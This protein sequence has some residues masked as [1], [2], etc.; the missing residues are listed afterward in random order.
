MSFQPSISNGA[1]FWGCA[2]GSSSAHLGCYAANGLSTEYSNLASP[3]MKRRSFLTL[4]AMGCVSPGVIS[5][6]ESG[7]NKP[8]EASLFTPITEGVRRATTLTVYEGLP[9]QADIVQFR[10][11]LATKKT[12]RLQ[13]FSFYQQPLE[14]FAADAKP[15]RR[16]CS[17]PKSFWSYGGMKLCGDFH[18]DYA[19]VWK[20]GDQVYNFLICLGCHEMRIHG[21]KGGMLVDIRDDPFNHFKAILL[22]YREQRPPFHV[23]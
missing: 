12:V 19:L 6:F 14:V 4:L 2:S 10:H 11:E 20:D 15:L 18:P 5:G 7:G 16:L 17:D 1:F 21:P 22:Q 8:V 13:G 3:L 9:H 23:R